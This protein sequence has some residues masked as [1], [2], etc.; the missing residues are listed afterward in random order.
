LLHEP[1]PF[2]EHVGSPIGLLDFTANGMRK[3]SPYNLILK[4]CV[5][6]RPGFGSHNRLLRRHR[7]NSTTFPAF[8]ARQ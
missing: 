3:R 6:S 4:R 5:L 7:L 1:P 2:L 8:A